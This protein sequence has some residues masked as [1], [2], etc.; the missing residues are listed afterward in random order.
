MA[1]AGDGF[2]TP[3]LGSATDPYACMCSGRPLTDIARLR[4]NEK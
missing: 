2:S 4:E 3:R 1:K